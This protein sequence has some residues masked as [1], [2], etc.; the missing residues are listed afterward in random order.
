MRQLTPHHSFA[1]WRRIGDTS[2]VALTAAMG[3][4]LLMGT[5][6]APTQAAGATVFPLGGG[7]YS[8]STHIADTPGSVTVNWRQESASATIDQFLQ[9]VEHGQGF[10]SAESIK[11][12]ARETTP[13]HYYRATATGLKPNTIYDYRV[14]SDKS[15]WS[16][17]FSFTTG[18]QSTGSTPWR[19]A[20]IGASQVANTEGINSLNLL[21]KQ[22]SAIGGISFVADTGEATGT[23]TTSWQYAMGNTLRR[24]QINAAVSFDDSDDEFFYNT[25]QSNRSTSLGSD[26]N[27]F[28]LHNNTLIIG[29]NWENSV[30]GTVDYV[31]KIATEHGANA[32]WTVVIMHANPFGVGSST[33]AYSTKDDVLAKI[34]SAFNAAGVDLVLTG[35]EHIYS[36]TFPMTGVTP[37]T[38][39]KSGPNDL[40]QVTGNQTVWVG[41]NSSTS[42]AVGKTFYDRTGV[43][44]TLG[45]TYYRAEEK[46]L[47]PE[48][49]AYWQQDSE[50]R[51]YHTSP[52]Y[53]VIDVTDQ[54]LTVTTRNVMD[55]F[56]VDQF[57]LTKATA[58]AGASTTVPVTTVV[59]ANAPAEPTS[60]QEPQPEEPPTTPATTA[61]TTVTATTTATTTVATPVPT[62]VAGATATT[63]VAGTTVTTTAPGGNTTV[64]TT[65][66]SGQ[67]G[68]STATVTATTTAAAEPQPLTNGSTDIDQQSLEITS[69]IGGVAAVLALIFGVVATFRTQ[70]LSLL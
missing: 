54:T 7:T 55:N 42:T 68:R 9:V 16:Q 70:I 31:K 41:L 30:S 47:N 5:V 43:A 12:E 35:R 49:I 27:W 48:E 50:S 24:S 36:R 39:K 65:V 40:W 4:S 17:T 52:D 34:G 2:A 14:G 33:D 20:A 21:S 26:R 8:V 57:T 13:G 15:G 37:D 61:T 64:T 6:A 53:S 51:F 3:T 44:Q 58:A 63:T 19:F 67:P 18:Q 56:L 32:K 22:L 45:F 60:S 25:S 11:W 69:I 46:N 62:T 28:A 59:P 29:V 66:S 38:S 23:G 1:A 10:A